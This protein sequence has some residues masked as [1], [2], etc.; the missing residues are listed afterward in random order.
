MV[1]NVKIS[2]DISR[3]SMCYGLAFT[4]F[5]WYTISCIQIL[6]ELFTE[7]IVICNSL[8]REC[9]TLLDCCLA[10]QT[11]RSQF[12]KHLVC[13]FWNPSNANITV[14]SSNSTIY[15]SVR[16]GMW[17]GTKRETWPCV[18]VYWFKVLDS[19]YTEERK[20]SFVNQNSDRVNI[21]KPKACVEY[22]SGI[23]INK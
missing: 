3:H 5:H 8:E 10:L 19:I 6:F 13:I 4:V 18:P 22:L 17:C 20:M 2:T 14:N 12:L 21:S 16:G 1:L 9:C 15:S 23:R 11:Y 7:D